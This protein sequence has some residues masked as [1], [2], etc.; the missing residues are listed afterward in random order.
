MRD[1]RYVDD[2]S[3]EEIANFVSSQLKREN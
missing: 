1:G 2:L 3:V